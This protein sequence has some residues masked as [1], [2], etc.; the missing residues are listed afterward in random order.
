MADEGTE[1][2][3]VMKRPVHD[4]VVVITLAGC[5][6]AFVVMGELHQIHAVPFA[7]VSIYFLSTF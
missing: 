7:V 2:V 4:A 3:V 1:D 5:Q 6:N